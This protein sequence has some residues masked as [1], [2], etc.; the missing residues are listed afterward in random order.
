MSNGRRS[1]ALFGCVIPW[2]ADR[3]SSVTLKLD[4]SYH[5]EIESSIRG[6]KAGEQACGNMSTE[7]AC[8][9]MSTEQACSNM[10]TEQACSNMSTE[11]NL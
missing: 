1:I 4:L 6:R 10:S 7:Q 2:A 8:G 3:P 11:H 9:N 5:L